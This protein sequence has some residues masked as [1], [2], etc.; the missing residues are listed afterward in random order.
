MLIS[1]GKRYEMLK[2]IFSILIIT[3]FSISCSEL[4]ERNSGSGDNSKTSS[5]LSWTP[6]TQN[7]DNSSLQPGEIV[8][9]RIYYGIQQSSLSEFI[10][11]DALSNPNSY[12]IEYSA[13][14]IPNGTTIYIAMTAIDDSQIESDLSEIISFNSH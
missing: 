1:D 3:T 4:S 6:P 12:T 13:N 9:Y 7:N 14:D 5:T 2:T 11:I 8:N 10:E